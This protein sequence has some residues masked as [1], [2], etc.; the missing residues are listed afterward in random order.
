MCLIKEMGKKVCYGFSFGIGVGLS[1]NFLPKNERNASIL[2]GSSIMKNH[3][4]KE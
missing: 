4:K 1:I 3:I 2:P